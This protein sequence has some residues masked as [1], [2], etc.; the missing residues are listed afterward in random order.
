M[1]LSLLWEQRDGSIS[2]V[3]DPDRGQ[4]EFGFFSFN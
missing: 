2:T 4:S 3:I 1:A